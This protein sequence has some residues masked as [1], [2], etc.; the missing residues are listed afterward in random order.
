MADSELPESTSTRW[1]RN[2]DVV[3]RRIGGRTILVPTGR[4]IADHRALFTLNDAA[5]HV[6]DQL[7]TAR[8]GE[9]LVRSLCREFDV[10]PAQARRDIG[11]FVGEM[12]RRGCIL[13]LP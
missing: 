13:E 12:K 5:S 2:P 11:I 3:A 6:W 10:T 9:Q 4:G 1:A 7:A 8:S